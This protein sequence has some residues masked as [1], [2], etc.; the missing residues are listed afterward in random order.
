[1]TFAQV[2]DPP[3]ALAEGLHR[4]YQGVMGAGF[5][6]CYLARSGEF[7]ASECE[8]GTMKK[9]PFIFS[10]LVT[11]RMTGCTV[12]P[13]YSQVVIETAQPT[14]GDI[15]YARMIAERITRNRGGSFTPLG[16]VPPRVEP[17]TS[18]VGP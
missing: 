12:S 8:R 10:I 2:S 3:N 6:R 13:N 15:D 16:R 5:K 7:F 1:M 9:H 11:A 17:S 14:F 4:S 18:S